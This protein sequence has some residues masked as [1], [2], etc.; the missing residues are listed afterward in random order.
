MSQAADARSLPQLLSDLARELTTLFRKETQLVKAEVAEKVAQLQL[1]VMMI[2]LGALVG[3]IALNVL[4]GALVAAIAK[5]GNP[6]IGPGWAALIVGVLL[7][8]AAGIL[9]KKG[10][11]DLKPS[12]LTPD[13]SV[14][15]VKEDVNLMKEQVR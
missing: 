13:K 12:N 10:A 15:Q 7:A 1:G 9:A 5:I 2:V 6:D 8:V 11:S 4:A 14:H 3:L